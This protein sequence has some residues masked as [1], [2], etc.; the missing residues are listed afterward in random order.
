MTKSPLGAFTG[1]EGGFFAFAAPASALEKVNIGRGPDVPARTE[2]TSK[3]PE[4]STDRT[5]APPW[6]WTGPR[7]VVQK[8]DGT[9]TE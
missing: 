4:H 5:T 2:M 8:T 1:A 9:M 6:R 3:A 7:S